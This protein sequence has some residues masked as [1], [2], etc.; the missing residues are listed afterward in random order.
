MS[1]SLATLCLALLLS[2]PAHAGERETASPP[3]TTA[4]ALVA[5]LAHHPSPLDRV[6]P[7][8]RALFLD[9]LDFG[10]RGVRSFPYGELAH[11]LTTA[12]L[13]EVQRLLLDETMPLTGLHADEAG[14]LRAARD[15]GTLTAPSGAVLTAYRDWRTAKQAT[16]ATD[17]AIDRLA[18]EHAAAGR[19]AGEDLRLLHRAAL[20]RAW[21]HGDDARIG[22]A[23]ALHAR[24]QAL[25]LA[26]RGDHRDV[27]RA[28]LRAGRVEEARAFTATVPDADLPAVPRLDVTRP[29]PDGAIR[30]WQIEDDD[31][32]VPT[33]R[34]DALDLDARIVV[35]SAPGCGFSR[36]AAAAIPSDAELGPVFAQYAVWLI[37]PDAIADVAALREWNRRNPET[38]ILI[39]GDAAQWP[40]PLDSTPQFLVFRGGRLVERIDGWPL[41][42]SR[43]DAVHAALLRAGLLHSTVD[44][45]DAGDNPGPTSEYR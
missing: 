19:S 5:W 21:L 38:G 15:A 10:P 23:R 16:D 42:G 7:H 37:A 24:L 26:T 8:T 34:Q 4:E 13:A 36:A 29:L 40:V 20:E 3:F 14:R 1:R 17:A 2:M 30:I 28:L 11:E 43:R 35:V 31:E 22:T 27:Q 9:A 39:A 18:A 12:E 6:P 44:A 45:A 32:T 41:D 25:G 33:L